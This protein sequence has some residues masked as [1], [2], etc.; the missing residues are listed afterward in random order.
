MRAVTNGRVPDADPFACKAGL[1][2]KLLP[3]GLLILCFGLFACADAEAVRLNHD[4]P[5]PP[6]IKRLTEPGACQGGESLAAINLP[7]P[8]FPRR[9]KW[10]KRQGWVVISLDVAEDGTTKNVSARRSAPR[11]IFEKSAIRAVQTWQF[12][13]PGEQGLN[14]CLVFISYRL[15]SVR[16]GN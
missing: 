1:I 13:P 11:D 14:G 16:I 5:A 6:S 9:A 7:L 2:M 3:I 15:G 10:Q 4:Y 12:E 8:K